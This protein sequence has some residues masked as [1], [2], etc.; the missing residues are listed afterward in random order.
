MDIRTRLTVQGAT[1]KG[2]WEDVKGGNS[3][4]GN[5]AWVPEQSSAGVALDLACDA[6]STLVRNVP[7][8]AMP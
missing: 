5:L 1:L 6:V 3:G 7:L 4:P 8:P 2:R